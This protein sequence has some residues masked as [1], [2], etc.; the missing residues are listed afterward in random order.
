MVR[1]KGRYLCK[2]N[3]RQKICNVFQIDK[4]N[5]H[6]DEYRM[7]FRWLDDF[8]RARFV[9]MEIFLVQV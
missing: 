4:S 6:T 8:D 2:H 7:W 9:C 5:Y 1:K 3:N